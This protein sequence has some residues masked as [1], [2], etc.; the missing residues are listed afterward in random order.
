[1]SYELHM[2]VAPMPYED[3]GNWRTSGTGF[4][5]LRLT[6]E[7]AGVIDTEADIPATPTMPW[8]PKGLEKELADKIYKTLQQG[9][10]LPDTYRPADVGACKRYIEAEKKCQQGRS[11]VPGKVPFWKFISNEGMH[12]LPEECEAIADGIKGLL[13]APP[14]DL[15][16]RLGYEDSLDK[17]MG[18]LRD[19]MVYNR[20]AASHGGYKVC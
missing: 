5:Q 17:L 11:A 15:P 13:K 9:L 7:L 12:V 8:P 1:M 2:Q 20:L 3:R 14:P 19:W 6:M 16:V 18:W 10:P 4:E